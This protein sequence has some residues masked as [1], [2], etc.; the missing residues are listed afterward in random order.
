MSVGRMDGRMAGLERRLHE[1]RIKKHGKAMKIA[2]LKKISPTLQN[3]PKAKRRKVMKIK[4]R[5]LGFIVPVKV[6][7][8][9]E[10][11]EEKK[12]RIFIPPQY[13]LKI[14]KTRIFYPPSALKSRKPRIFYPHC[15]KKGRGP[16]ASEAAGAAAAAK[17]RSERSGPRWGARYPPAGGRQAL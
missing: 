6:F 12:S 5:N 17:R 4:A 1:R 15:S 3:T 8:I 14:A 7:N 11:R 16:R 9:F 10:N 2:K 13:V